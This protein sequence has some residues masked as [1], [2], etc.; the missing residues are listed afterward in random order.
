MPITPEVRW[1]DDTEDRAWRAVWTLM[2][3]LPTRLDAQLRAE[4]GM[5]LAEYNALSQISEAPRRT[6]RLSELGQIANMTLSHLS[7][8]ITKMEQAGWVTRAPDPADGRATVA[9]L[10]PA[11]W[12]KV[13]ATAPGHVAA[14]RRYVLD[15]LTPQQVTELGGAAG[16]IADRVT[17]PSL[18]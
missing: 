11:G 5:S 10:T 12:D 6:L 2:T 1:L 7:R 15:D 18:R 9:V 17:P 4:A 14:V 16:L 13:V 3:W 8:V